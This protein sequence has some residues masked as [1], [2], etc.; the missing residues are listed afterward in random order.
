MVHL[1]TMFTFK[2]KYNVLWS[3]K[4]EITLLKYIEIIQKNIVLKVEF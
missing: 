3:K 4:D 1:N 2:Y